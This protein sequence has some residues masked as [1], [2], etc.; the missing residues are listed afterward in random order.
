[1]AKQPVKNVNL[2]V[3]SVALEDDVQEFALNV[4]QEVPPVT[5]ISDAGPRRVAGNYDYN[6][7]LSGAGDFASGQSDA[8]LFNMLG[9]SG[10]AVAVDPTGAASPGANDPHY[11]ST[12]MV[13]ESYSITGK[14]GEAV[15]FEATLQGNAALTR[16]VA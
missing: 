5:A 13:L 1:V 9:S 2:A 7:E 11:D 14:V 12:S 6:L 3:N 16:S 10:V 8:T 4:E 15:M